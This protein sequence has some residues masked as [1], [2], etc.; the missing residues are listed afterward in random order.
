TIGSLTPLQAG[1]SFTFRASNNVQSTATST[2]KVHLCVTANSNEV[3]GG[4]ACFDLLADLDLPTGVT[5]TFIAGPDGIPNNADDGTL[6]ET[7]DTDRNGDGKFST[8]D[9]FR[10]QDAGT[11]LVGHATYIHGSATGVGT[12]V[13]AGIE[14]I[15]RH[16]ENCAS[17]FEA[18]L[19]GAGE[20][21]F[22]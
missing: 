1:S 22:T 21:G 3:L 10:L 17:P 20:I 19:K 4:T 5:Q 2:A 18:A 12:D 7:F 14:N 8:D 11:G 6:E 13:V 15:V 16:M 9:I